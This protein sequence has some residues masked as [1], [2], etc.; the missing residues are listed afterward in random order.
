MKSTSILMILAVA[1]AGASS[2]G[3]RSNENSEVKIVGGKVVRA[4]D[5]LSKFTI[6]LVYADDR[7][8]FC[9][10]TLIGPR[11]VLTAAHC[12]EEVNAAHLEIGAAF[13]LLT[14]NAQFVPATKSIQHEAYNTALMDAA[15]PTG[16][17]NDIGLVTLAEDA[18]AG[19]APTTPLTT[20]D[21]IEV[22]EPLTL[23]GFGLTAPSGPDQ[24]GIL[25]QV[26]T[27]I[28][29][30]SDVRKELGFGKHVGH[31]ACMGDSG[32]PA[33]VTRAGKLALVGVTSRGSSTCNEKGIYTDA[34]HFTAWIASNR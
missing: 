11:T 9:T 6:A 16:A 29:L 4:G 33:F 14:D 10:G 5:P 25:R 27:E 2:C 23:A 8:E 13:G 1:I 28:V 20:A 7:T 34:R 17:P 30:V 26:A 15:T 24:S 32:G 3:Q 12:L 31:S 18:P 21:Q 19:Y 22:G